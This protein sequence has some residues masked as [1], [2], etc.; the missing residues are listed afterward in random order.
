MN[1]STIIYQIDGATYC[2]L[3]NHSGDYVSPVKQRL[4]IKAHMQDCL[5]WDV[6][7]I[8]DSLKYLKNRDIRCINIIDVIELDEL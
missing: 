6:D 4:A 2:F 7:L 1:Q 3:L 5:E 8:A